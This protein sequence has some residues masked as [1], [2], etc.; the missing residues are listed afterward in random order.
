MVDQISH[1]F[2]L[3]WKWEKQAKS[4]LQLKTCATANQFQNTTLI[5]YSH[6]DVQTPGTNN[7][8]HTN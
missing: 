5:I 8:Y 6:L 7:V 4:W 2:V 3:D 1:R